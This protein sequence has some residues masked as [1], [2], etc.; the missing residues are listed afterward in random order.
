MII[1]ITDVNFKYMNEYLGCTDRLVITPL[2]DRCY[3]TLAQVTTLFS[4][5]AVPA[6]SW[7]VHGGSPCRSSWYWQDGDCQGHGQGG[8]CCPDET[9]RNMCSFLESTVWSSIAALNRIS[10]DLAGKTAVCLLDN[11]FAFHH[12]S[13]QDLQGPGTI[14]YLGM[15]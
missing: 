3:I 8:A 12:S 1:S 7:H 11:I 4:S 2:T 10:K 6:G 9:Y 14:R 5:N 15:F 13:R